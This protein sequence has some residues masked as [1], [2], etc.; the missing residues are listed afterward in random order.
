LSSLSQGSE[1][2]EE[3]NGIADFVPFAHGEWA[4]TSEKAEE[5]EQELWV[6]QESAVPYGQAEMGKRHG[7][8]LRML[9]C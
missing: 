5:E 9:S 7:P 6:L 2:Q 4:R 3:T 1:P 8:L